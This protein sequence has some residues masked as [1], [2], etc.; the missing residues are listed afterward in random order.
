MLQP[1]R[2]N[3]ASSKFEKIAIREQPVYSKI[4]KAAIKQQHWQGRQKQHTIDVVMRESPR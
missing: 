4:E 1:A 3:A 2:I